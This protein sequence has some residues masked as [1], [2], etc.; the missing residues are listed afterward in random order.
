MFF[1]LNKFTLIIPLLVTILSSS[2]CEESTTNPLLRT[3]IRMKR[4]DYKLTLLTGWNSRVLEG[5]YASG[6]Y[7]RF[8]MGFKPL[9][10]LGVCEGTDPDGVKMSSSFND[11]KDKQNNKTQ[12]KSTYI[13]FTMNVINN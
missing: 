12:L 7:P 3:C 13:L 9:L 4:I 2:S 11:F 6:T 10:K 8:T 5:V 1:S